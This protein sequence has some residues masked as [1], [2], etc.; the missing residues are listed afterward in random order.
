MGNK[1]VWTTAG[2]GFVAIALLAACAHDD[3]AS[4]SGASD[5]TPTTLSEE[6][7]TRRGSDFSPEYRQQMETAE[8]DAELKKQSKKKRD[9]RV[10]DIINRS[11]RREN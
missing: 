11:D 9:K 3:L 1:W 4:R 5:T 8:R 6:S 2:Q 10:D 7:V